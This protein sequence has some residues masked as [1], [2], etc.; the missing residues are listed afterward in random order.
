MIEQP[1]GGRRRMDAATLIMIILAAGLSLAAYLRGGQHLAGWLQGGRMLWANLLLLLASFIVAGL[2]QVL[3]PQDLVRHW[4]GTDAGVKGV[5]LGCVA[6]ALAPGPP[7]AVFPIVGSFYQAGAAIGSVVGFVSA[8]GLWSVTRLPTE[9]ALIDP[10]VA[11]VR[12]VSTLVVPPL[13][14]LFAQYVLGPA[15]NI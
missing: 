2:V 7:Y 15:V 9:A 6:G 13:A 1:R 11:L 3:V 8:W 12:F 5:L 4:L 14:G 10:K